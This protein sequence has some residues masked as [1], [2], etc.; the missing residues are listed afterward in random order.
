MIRKENAIGPEVYDERNLVT[1]GSC[2]TRV[3][4][5]LR[6][7]MAFLTPAHRDT[8]LLG[9]KETHGVTMTALDLF[10]TETSTRSE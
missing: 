5:W 2:V 7:A 8:T 9:S 3:H 4:A 1:R 10:N 6:F